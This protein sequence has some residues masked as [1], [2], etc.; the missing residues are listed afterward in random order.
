MNIRQ[1][2]SIIDGAV[3]N[4]DVPCCAAA[5][6]VGDDP[7]FRYITGDRALF[8][9]RL[10]LTDDTLFDL[11]SLTKMTATAAAA[12]RL[13][14]SGRLSLAASVGDYFDGCGDKGGITVGQLMSHTS[15]LPAHIPLWRKLSDPADAF[16]EIF[17]TPFSCPAGTRAVYSCMGYI[18]LGRIL[19]LTE[20]EPL[21]ALTERLV[22]RPLGMKD[23][24]F[25]PDKARRFA[26]TELDPGTG[27]YVCGEVHD[28]N[29]RFLGGAA[30]NAGLF[31]PLDD[32]VKIAAVFSKRG[33]G[34]ISPELFELAI[35]D[36]SPLCEGYGLGF[37][38]RAENGGGFPGGDFMSK[39]SYGHTGFTGTSLFVDRESGIYAVM[40]TNRVHP[41]R[42]NNKHVPLRKA[43]HAEVIKMKNEG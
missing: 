33:E 8:P 39:G 22:L 25:C 36:Q 11:A 34:F 10:P 40:L 43:F 4:G 20:D 2:E 3:K 5:A 19:E 7:V 30:G 16:G 27:R 42:T 18:L 9:E 38:L 28:E 14:D 21:T 31:A 41:S 13:I 37:T 29:A 12:L 35:T 23:S 6:G 24:G 32:L 1:L 17:N 15:G 26:S